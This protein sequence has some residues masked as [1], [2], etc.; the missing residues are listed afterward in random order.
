MTHSFPTRRSSDL[1]LKRMAGD[2]SGNWSTELARLGLSHRLTQQQIEEFF[3][4]YP[5]DG[6]VALADHTSLYRQFAAGMDFDRLMRA[7]PAPPPDGLGSTN[8]VVSG[9]RTVTGA[10][11]GRA[12]V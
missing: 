10:Q 9:K 6:P 7:L 2:L 5:G 12:H 4:P 11:I 1:W 3:P 8:W